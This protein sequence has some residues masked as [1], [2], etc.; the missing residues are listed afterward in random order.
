MRQAPRKNNF[1]IGGV[2]Q[3]FSKGMRCQKNGGR[4][5]RVPRFALDG[6][7]GVFYISDPD[8]SAILF[9]KNRK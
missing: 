6:G 1:R 5:M 9:E 7:G 2:I 3:T 8:I 4:K